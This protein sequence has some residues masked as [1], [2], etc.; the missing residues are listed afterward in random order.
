[1]V[2]LHCASH[3]FDIL[4]RPLATFS[5]RRQSKPE[6]DAAVRLRRI[7]AIA[8]TVQNSVM[9]VCLLGNFG[10][11]YLS[12]RAVAGQHTFADIG[13][14]LVGD[15]KISEG[16]SYLFGAGGIG[17]GLRERRLRRQTTERIAPRLAGHEKTIDRSRTSS[18]LT[19]RGTTHP[20][21]RI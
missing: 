5:Q 1:M 15:F 11:V 7:D 16:I 10:L 18:H 17:Y 12:I 21:D 8:F 19:A 4:S 9:W 6:L 3:L 14:R 2:H 13:V 20:E